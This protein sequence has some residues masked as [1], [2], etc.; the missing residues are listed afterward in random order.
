ML[1]FLADCMASF[2]NSLKGVRVPELCV[3]AGLAALSVPCFDR[4]KEQREFADRIVSDYPSQSAY[5]RSN[6][7][8]PEAL[9][10]TFAWSAAVV[11]LFSIAGIRGTT[12]QKD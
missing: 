6:A 7:E 2:A 1:G 9:G 3:A 4:A 5:I 8:F 12:E 11:F 10:K